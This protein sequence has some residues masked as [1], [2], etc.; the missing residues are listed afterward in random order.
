V[1]GN[2]KR[3]RELEAQ[4]E[5]L[6]D[7]IAAGGLHGSRALGTRL[8]AAEAELEALRAAPAAASPV[9]TWPSSCPAWATPT[10]IWSTTS[11]NGWRAARLRRCARSSR[12]SSGRYACA[13]TARKSCWR[14]RAAALKWPS[15]KPR[16]SVEPLSK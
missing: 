8:Q 14:A 15:F 2:G 5:N 9:L 16:G 13:L 10:T 11:S 7:A 12:A 1:A 4:V 6:A 3:I